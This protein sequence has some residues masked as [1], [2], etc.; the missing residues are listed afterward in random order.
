MNSFYSFKYTVRQGYDM[1][2]QS[3]ALSISLMSMNLVFAILLLLLAIA[4]VV[5]RKTY[6]Y[7]P[8]HELKRQAA[9]HDRLAERLYM[10]AA[11]DSSLRGLLWIFIALTSAGG[12][13]L[14]SQTAPAWI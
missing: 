11:Y 14:L 6:N 7:L 13:V 9:K 2:L 1:P 12:F 4:G 10:A 3:G 5:V 8:A